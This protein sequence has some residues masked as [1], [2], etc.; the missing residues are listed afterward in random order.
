MGPV[1]L[2]F[3][4]YFTW[5]GFDRAPPP[6]DRRDRN[7]SFIGGFVGQQRL[8]LQPSL[9]FPVPWESTRLRGFIARIEAALPYR[10]RDQYFKRQV[11]SRN[12][13]TQGRSF[14][15]DRNWR[16]T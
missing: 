9:A 10:F 12:A 4:Y 3:V 16:S 2:S 7:T 14:K 1:W 6:I 13:R 8:F 5:K 11:P 15:L